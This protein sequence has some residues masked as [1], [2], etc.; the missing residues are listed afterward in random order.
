L[1]MLLTNVIAQFF[2]KFQ[3]KSIPL[4]QYQIEQNLNNTNP[5]C[6]DL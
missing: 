3:I 6:N 1:E 4:E 5:F 2:L